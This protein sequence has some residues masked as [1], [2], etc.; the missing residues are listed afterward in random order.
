ME[1][2]IVPNIFLCTSYSLTLKRFQ[3]C[4]PL[5]KDFN[6]QTDDEPR[7][8]SLENRPTPT[9]MSKPGGILRTRW[10]AWPNPQHKSVLQIPIPICIHC[11]PCDIT[12]VDYP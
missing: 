1:L 12:P 3:I 2:I 10:L 5:Q 8:M 4:S 7:I 6:A 9:G 11:P